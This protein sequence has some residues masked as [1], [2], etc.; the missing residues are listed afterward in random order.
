MSAHPAS[1][2]SGVLNLRDGDG[3][4]TNTYHEPPPELAEVVERFWSVRW[5]LRGRRPHLQHTLSNASVHL[6]FERG[7][8]RVQGVVTGRFTR[9][10]EGRGRV[11]GVKFRPAG[12]HVFLGSSLADVADRCLPVC[13]VFGP[14]GDALVSRVLDM[15]DEASMAAEAGEF[16][17]HR[18]P[19]PDPTV[20]AVNR[21]AALI[22]A[23]RS[24]T[25]VDHVVRLSG[26]RKRTLQ[27]LFREYVGVSPKWIIQRYRLHEA[28]RRL[29]EG[30]D[31]DLAALALDLGYFDQAHFVRDFKAIVGRP[32]GAHARS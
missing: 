30:H 10:L 19:P 16:L 31:V 6:C 2:R 15:E 7:N 27:R 3:V 20:A 32:P 14:E 29:E 21:V 11:F 18:L 9:L 25:R 1:T 28:A 22:V 26:L 5:D 8:S 13:W 23:D 12:F 17:R 4:Y 24:I